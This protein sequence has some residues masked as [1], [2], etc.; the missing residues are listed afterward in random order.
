MPVRTDI[1]REVS[2]ILSSK[3]KAHKLPLER[4]SAFRATRRDRMAPV[5]V[6]VRRRLHRTQERITVL[7]SMRQGCR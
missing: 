7:R 3:F 5:S 4:S 6:R 2:K 1:G